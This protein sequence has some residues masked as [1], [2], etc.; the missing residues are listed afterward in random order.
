MKK[1]IH[2]LKVFLI[3]LKFLIISPSFIVVTLVGNLIIV[4]M[5]LAFHF[6]EI[7][8]NEAINSFMDSI[9][10]SFSTITTVGYGDIV[11]KTFLGKIIGITSMLA[12]TAIFATYTAL[13]AQ[14]FLGQQRFSIK[15]I[16]TRENT[17]AE[18]LQK[19]EKQLRS[20]ERKIDQIAKD[21]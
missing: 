20:L 1:T 3:N 13:F 19:L 15:K 6:V 14:A 17:N 5:A 8:S 2:H 10:W 16:E 12:G 9:W 18:L 11:A 7:N 21:K 4:L